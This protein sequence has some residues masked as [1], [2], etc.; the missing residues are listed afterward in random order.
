MA[1]PSDFSPEL[2]TTICV[3][4]SSGQSLRSICDEDGMPDKATVFRWLAANETFRD[5]YA[6]AREAQADSMLED[7]FEIADQ[8]DNLKEKLDVEHIQRAKLRI[9]TRKW[10]M[11]KMS[12]KKYGD[13][14]LQQISGDPEQPLEINVTIGGNAGQP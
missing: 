9:D 5:Q 1:R 6:R 2:A 3:E 14:V 7:I 12:P 11:S 10:A 4:L 13:K 8:Y